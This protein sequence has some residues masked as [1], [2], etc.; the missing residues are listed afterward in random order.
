VSL[1]LRLRPAIQKV[2]DKWRRISKARA[3]LPLLQPCA[4]RVILVMRVWRPGWRPNDHGSRSVRICFFL[5]SSSTPFGIRASRRISRK[6]HLVLYIKKG[7]HS[8]SVGRSAASLLTFLVRFWIVKVRAGS[9]TR[10]GCNPTNAQAGLRPASPLSKTA[11]FSDG[12]LFL[13]SS[14]RIRGDSCAISA[15]SV[16]TYL[17]TPTNRPGSWSC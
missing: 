8:P 5:R 6:L 3:K 4:F 10:L 7:P 14:G 13:T 1:L 17:V 12:Q 9:P 15:I 11:T 2:F 16:Y